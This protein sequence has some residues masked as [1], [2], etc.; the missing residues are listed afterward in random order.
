MI[1]FTRSLKKISTHINTCICN[2][3]FKPPVQDYP[4]IPIRRRRLR[5]SCPAL[6]RDPV[7]VKNSIFHNNMNYITERHSIFILYCVEQKI[8]FFWILFL[9]IFTFWNVSLYF[10]FKTYKHYNY[11]Y[12]LNIILLSGDGSRQRTSPELSSASGIGECF[13][14]ILFSFWITQYNVL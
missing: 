1:S 7:T 4:Y 8:L 12:I 13:N 5:S 14:R 10:F 2:K 6:F 11:D 9:T 3:T